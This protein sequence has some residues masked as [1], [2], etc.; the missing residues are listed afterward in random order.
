MLN[1]ALLY[2]AGSESKREGG[3]AGAE[4]GLGTRPQALSVWMQV[5]VQ[6]CLHVQQAMAMAARYRLS[7]FFFW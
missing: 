6:Q 4:A 2:V 1:E 7:L 3:G 5:R